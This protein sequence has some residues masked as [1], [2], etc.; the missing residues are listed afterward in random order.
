MKL[1]NLTNAH[2]YFLQ[3]IDKQ[4]GI[5]CKK[6]DIHPFGRKACVWFDDTV[7]HVYAQYIN[8]HVERPKKDL[9]SIKFAINIWIAFPDNARAEEALC[10]EQ[11][12]DCGIK[13]L[14]KRCSAYIGAGKSLIEKNMWDDG[15]KRP[16]VIYTFDIKDFPVRGDIIDIIK[17][18]L[19]KAQ[20]KFGFS[21]SDN[22]EDFLKRFDRA[23]HILLPRYID[24]FKNRGYQ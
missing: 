18:L 7:F 10:L 6:P 12:L 4:D 24:I 3:L 9:K 8:Q 22:R 2:R 15:D 20:D 21:Y 5:I 23:K 13:L 16:H 1:F 11:Y 19:R 14:D 17:D